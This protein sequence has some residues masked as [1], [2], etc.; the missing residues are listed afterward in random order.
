MADPTTKRVKHAA[1]WGHGKEEAM[2]DASGSSSSGE[3]EGDE[4]ESDDYKPAQRR[5]QPAQ[6]GRPVRI[7]PINMLDAQWHDLCD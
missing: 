3:E 6:K 5:R 2:D 1:A 7:L 4:S